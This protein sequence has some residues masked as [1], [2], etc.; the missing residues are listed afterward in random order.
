MG[1]EQCADHIDKDI[2]SHPHARVG[3][4]L[5]YPI[6]NNA[7]SRIHDVCLTRLSYSQR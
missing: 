7:L 3:N 6:A 5:A 4:V 2:I 1:P